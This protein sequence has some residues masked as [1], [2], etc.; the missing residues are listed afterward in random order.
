MSRRPARPP[1]A[2]QS[3]LPFV[4]AIADK[5]WKKALADDPHLKNGLNVAFGKVT[6][7]PVAD[8]LGYEYIEAESV[9]H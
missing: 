8:A 7:K 9:L 4:L 5:G 3:H 1:R 6:C 2:Q